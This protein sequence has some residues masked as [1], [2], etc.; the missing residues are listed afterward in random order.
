MRI[1]LLSFV[2]MFVLAC[3][4]S[5][6]GATQEIAKTETNI[7]VLMRTEFME[8]CQAKPEYLRKRRNGTIEKHCKCIFKEAMKG[9][10]DEERIVAGFYL[11]GEQHEGFKKRLHNRPPDLDA[12]VPAVKA[13]GRAAKKCR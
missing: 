7:T 13:I 4:P 1:L 3:S 12:M 6:S 11:Y 5:K 10:S 8:A 9:L 2:V